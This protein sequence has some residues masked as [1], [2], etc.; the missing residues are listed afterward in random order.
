MTAT[1]QNPEGIS[2]GDIYEDVFLHPCLCLGVEEGSAWGVSLIDG[3]YPRSC[4]LLMSGIRK[5]TPDEAWRIKLSFIS[6]PLPRP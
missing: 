4:D 1:L 5:L 6:P 3:S 2:V